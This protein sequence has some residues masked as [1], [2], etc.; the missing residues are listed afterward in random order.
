[1]VNEDLY[2]PDFPHGTES[3]YQRGC[4]SNGACPANVE[5]GQS[6]AKAHGRYTMDHSYRR[7]VDNGAT[8]EIQ[9][10]SEREV[11]RMLSEINHIPAGD[12]PTVDEVKRPTKYETSTEREERE[13]REM[14]DRAWNK[15]VPKSADSEVNV[16]RETSVDVESSEA[17]DEGDQRRSDES[18]PTPSRRAIA[19]REN[20]RRQ[21]EHALATVS[22]EAPFGRTMSGEPRRRQIPGAGPNARSEARDRAA[23]DLRA[24]VPEPTYPRH[25]PTR[26]EAD[27]ALAARNGKVLGHSSTDGV[28]SQDGGRFTVGATSNPDG[29]VFIDGVPI[30]PSPGITPDAVT[31]APSSEDLAYLR[32]QSDRLASV[33][34]GF[35]ARALGDR[36]A[37]V[38]AAVESLALLTSA[39][40][41]ES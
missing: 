3:G 10:T 20:V 37:E 9:R 32:E 8:L 16:S 31:G 41:S 12:A 11:R 13:V 39:L 28:A 26:E 4:H 18:D 25:R 15:H 35:D 21:R 7:V 23:A 5:F 14:A 17:I 24:T 29:P 38:A 27:A 22:P 36:L 6:C 34:G 19:Q 2:A 1:M 30:Y 40:R 33:L